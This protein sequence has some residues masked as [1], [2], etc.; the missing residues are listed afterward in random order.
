MTKGRKIFVTYGNGAYYKSLE[1]IRREVEA[2]GRFDEIRIYTDK[3]LPASF[4]QHELFTYS[5][6]G[7]YWF[8]KPWVV[9]DTMKDMGED[10]ILV[11]SDAGS[12]IH[13]HKEW[14][15]WFKIL[16]KKSA[17]FFFYS[18]PMA[19]WTRK[20]VLEHFGNV[21]KLGSYYQLIACLFALRKS[22]QHLIK[23]WFDVMSAYPEIVMDVE[24]DMMKYENQGFVENRHDQ[25]ILSGV[26]Y[27][28][29]KEESIKILYQTCEIRHPGGQAVF[30]ARKSDSGQR[31]NA[32]VFPW[33]L[34]LARKC[35][36]TPMRYMRFYF[37][38]LNS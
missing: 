22:A 21:R 11:Y 9:L 19:K 2:T 13:D 14:D 25:S 24:R 32:T 29:L 26:I 3:D 27:S 34:E 6:G 20:S 8:W 36:I 18:E 35:I 10:D 17:L 1:R 38:K 31:N 23:E 4:K 15:R 28:H 37:L 30:A 5:R 16:S 12:E 33:H 7:G